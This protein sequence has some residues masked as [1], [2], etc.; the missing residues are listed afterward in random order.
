M[1]YHQAGFIALKVRAVGELRD[2]GMPSHYVGVWENPKPAGNGLTSWT[3]GLRLWGQEV[4][5]TYIE[6]SHGKR[7][8]R[9]YPGRIYV[10]PKRVSRARV[11]EMMV[12]RSTFIADLLAN[13]GWQLTDPEV[14]GHP[15]IAKE[16]DVLAQFIPAGVGD[17]TE[18]ISVDTSTS[19]VETEMGHCD[20]DEKIQ[21]YANIPSTLKE[22]RSGVA[23]NASAI[24]Q[25]T[26]DVEN[27][28]DSVRAG[29][30]SIA[31]MRSE[32]DGLKGVANEVI[33]LNLLY[34]QALTGVSGNIGL[35]AEIQSKML[36]MDIKEVQERVKQTVSEFDGRGYQ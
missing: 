27:V 17:G 12:A 15:H 32:L 34:A 1:G 36:G 23:A 8:F 29:A 33:E 9:V 3:C 26:S 11:I 25:V 24:G 6:S 30:V 16:N 19:D 5:A 20:D 22:I 14:K 4:K 28:R 35:M 31:Q 7:Q 10:D 2:V 13:H 18:D 21:I